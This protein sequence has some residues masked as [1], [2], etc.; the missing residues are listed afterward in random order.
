MGIRHLEH[1]MTYDVPH[2]FHNVWLEEE[3]QNFER[4]FFA[5]EQFFASANF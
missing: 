1:F 2:G 3:I 5:I 4:L